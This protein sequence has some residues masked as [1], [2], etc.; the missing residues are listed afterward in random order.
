MTTD[1]LQN[2]KERN[3]IDLHQEE[4]QQTL[5]APVEEV[6]YSPINRQGQ[7]LCVECLT[8]PAT[9]IFRIFPVC[10]ECWDVLYKERLKAARKKQ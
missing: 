1:F 4:S 9:L 5:K 8:N 10:Q 6:I 3:K 2:W 7:R